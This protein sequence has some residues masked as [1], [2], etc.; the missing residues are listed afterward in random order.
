MAM[1]FCNYRL[2]RVMLQLSR[3]PQSTSMRTVN[4]IDGDLFLKPR[5]PDNANVQM[6]RKMFDKTVVNVHV[7]RG[8]IVVK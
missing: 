8:E 5:E 1:L 4:G 3:R 7:R 2:M 6:R